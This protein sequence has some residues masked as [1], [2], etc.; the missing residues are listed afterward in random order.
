MQYIAEFSR[1]KPIV[2]CVRLWLPTAQLPQGPAHST[3][4]RNWMKQ[5]D[6]ML[7]SIRREIKTASQ[8]HYHAQLGELC[9][10]LKRVALAMDAAT[11]TELD[12]AETLCLIKDLQLMGRY[13]DAHRLLHRKLE[14]LVL[15]EGDDSLVLAQ[16]YRQLAEVQLALQELESAGQHAHWAQDIFISNLGR[17]HEHV[18]Q[19]ELQLIEIALLQGHLPEVR[20]RVETVLADADRDMEYGLPL[21]ARAL[22]LLAIAEGIQR[23][24]DCALQMIRE[25]SA[26]ARQTEP[27]DPALLP[28]LMVFEGILQRKRTQWD[29]AEALFLEAQDKLQDLLPPYHIDIGRT[30]L[31]A[32]RLYVLKQDFNRASELM[33]QA[34]EAFRSLSPASL[35][36]AIAASFRA[37]LFRMRGKKQK[38]MQMV[39][40][41]L[42]ACTRLTIP[43]EWQFR[44]QLEKIHV[45]LSQNRFA[46]AIPCIEELLQDTD[47]VTSEAPLGELYLLLG[48]ACLHQRDLA[49]AQKA[50]Y[51]A[52]ECPAEPE[53]FHLHTHAHLDLAELRLLQR[54]PQEALAATTDALH[55]LHRH[56]LDREQLSGRRACL[57]GQIAIMQA[58]PQQAERHFA[59]ALDCLA[60]VETPD[61]GL[62]ALCQLWLAQAC[63]QQGKAGQIIEVLGPM[64]E[65]QTYKCLPAEEDRILALYTLS[66]AHYSVNNI[67]KACKYVQRTFRHLQKNRDLVRDPN[68]HLRTGLLLGNTFLHQHRHQA[69]INALCPLLEELRDYLLQHPQEQA[70][71]HWL[72]GQAYRHIGKQCKAAEQFRHCLEIRMAYHPSTAL[73]V[74]QARQELAASLDSLQDLESAL[75]E[76]EVLYPSMPGPDEEPSRQQIRFRIADLCLQTGNLPRAADLADALLDANR[77]GK[78]PVPT[79][80]EYA[81][82]RAR[83]HLAAEEPGA[84]QHRLRQVLVRC[85]DRQ[86]EVTAEIHFVLAPLYTANGELDRAMQ[87]WQ[88]AQRLFEQH[89]QH[90]RHLQCLVSL[91]ELQWQQD[92]RTESIHTI[93][94]ALQVA[95]AH[96][97]CIS[98]SEL[99]TLYQTQGDRYA[100]LGNT[101][102]ALVSYNE[103]LKLANLRKC[104]KY[105]ALAASC[106]LGT[107]DL[108][109][110]KEAE[111][112]YQKIQEIYSRK[113]VA[114]D[115][116]LAKSFMECGLL[117]W[118]SNEQARAR[119]HMQQAHT[120]F[121]E[122][123][124]A[125]SADALRAAQ[126]LALMYSDAGEFTQASDLLQTLHEM[127]RPDLLP[128]KV[129]TDIED[130][131]LLNSVL[132]NM[133]QEISTG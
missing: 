106:L 44:L 128:P 40:Q 124:A 21:V 96:S 119:E 117:L 133:G 51:R 72:L 11:D 122:T 89:D 58:D 45:L 53:D 81:L 23:R 98:R 57:L 39:T 115:A 66:F 120:I 113:K 2:Q 36:L 75:A 79:L 61:A 73:L 69:M 27:D 5:T 126:Y 49:A 83:V 24:F 4:F 95:T 3:A 6:R 26:L 25:A 62:Q 29:D 52:L 54:K 109:E 127:S 104:S 82:L 74:R 15:D 65:H 32:G 31:E 91:S 16:G 90:E 46:E 60:Q 76:Y 59:E 1:A 97:D 123:H 19:C 99:I 70:T 88:E 20:N 14:A 64:I 42:E 48:R 8:S 116:L 87:T 94:T 121:Q 100:Q 30:N 67:E 13:T 34:Y 33:Q 12:H 22:H 118:N 68:I 47:Q 50:L 7:R 130:H 131:L 10:A 114:R 18:W 17:E 35:D 78:N 28:K 55:S 107:A 92:L 132:V 71:V 129:R 77:T 101:K 85:P 84:A 105:V 9:A 111:R 43:A 112:R 103:G 41:G 110:C 80:L 38:A 86:D 63:E 108:L 56:A 102:D 125:N 37:R 93:A